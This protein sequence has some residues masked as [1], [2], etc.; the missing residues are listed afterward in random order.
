MSSLRTSYFESLCSLVF[1]SRDE[2][3]SLS[4]QDRHYRH[5]VT[6]HVSTVHV[7]TVHVSTVHVSTVY[8]S[9]VHVST[10]HVSTVHVST[11]HVYI[12]YTYLH[13]NRLH[14]L[15]HQNLN[16]LMEHVVE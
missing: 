14:V 13:G 12:Q 3:E 8:V 4:G 7:S 5:V 15:V 10:V 1:Y 6:V 2:V 11:V 16:F 9:T